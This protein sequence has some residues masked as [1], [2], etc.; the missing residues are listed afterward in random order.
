M[1][2]YCVTGVT[3]MTNQLRSVTCWVYEGLC[4]RSHS[5]VLNDATAS[6][7]DGGKVCG[8]VWAAG[9]AGPAARRECVTMT[10]M[11]VLSVCV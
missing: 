3:E 1:S 8:A 5:H 7:A 2:V 10:Y 11:S 6:V 9:D 4:T